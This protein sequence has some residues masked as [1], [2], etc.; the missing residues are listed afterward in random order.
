MDAATVNVSANPLGQSIVAQVNTKL[1]DMSEVGFHFRKEKNDKGEVI[2]E[3]RPSFKPKLPLITIAGIA[4]ALAAGDKTSQLV[5][6]AV[7]EVI[8]DRMRGLINA[9]LELEPSVVLA[10]D[11]FDLNKLSLLEI[12]NLP[13]SERGAGISK[14]LWAA[15]VADYKATM[16]KPAA[17]AMFPDKKART[18][19][20]LEKHGIV[21]GGKFNQ[22][23]SRKDVIGQM[24]GFI[25]I[26]AST[27]ENLEEHVACYEHLKAKGNQL[28]QSE[29]FDD[30]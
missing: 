15:F 27:T 20:V 17:I 23:R 4:A 14:E 30:L 18:P 6:D 12:A 1:V 29:N 5:V 11:Q 21:L 13:K 16:V 24:L 8:I 26:W 22:V 9:K 10:D 25:D 28:L 3:K 7:N 19:D 2:G